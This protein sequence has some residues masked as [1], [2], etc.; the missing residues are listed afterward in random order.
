[1]PSPQCATTAAGEK[2]SRGEQRAA[3]PQADIQGHHHHEAEHGGPGSQL[4]VATAGKK[5]K[6]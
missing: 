4:P 6:G 1:M 2:P 5:T 3:L